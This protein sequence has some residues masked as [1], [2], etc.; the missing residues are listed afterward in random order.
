MIWGLRIANRNDIFPQTL[1]SCF[2]RSLD[3]I[4]PSLPESILVAYSIDRA[5]ATNSTES[6]RHVLNLGHDLTFGLPVLHFANALSNS[7][8]N[9]FQYRFNCPMPWEGTWRGTAIHGQD[10]IW[11]LQNYREHLGAGQEEAAELL[12]SHL[13][14]F[15]CGDKPYEAENRQ[16]VMVYDVASDTLEN[17]SRFVSET[18]AHRD[19]RRS[20]MLDRVEP[21]VLD[22]ILDGWHAFM[23]A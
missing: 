15:C 17:R 1:A 21:I 12:A 4:D 13:I 11:A 22:K 5:V 3:E 23:S 8:C 7:G 10:L 2:S 18:L 14:V 16:G 9:V 6:T 19:K 20:S